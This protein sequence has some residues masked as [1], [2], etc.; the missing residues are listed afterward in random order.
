MN[1]GKIFAGWGFRTRT[2]DYEPGDEL[3]VYVTG[4]DGSPV[5]RIGDTELRLADGDASLVD[6]RI[7]V[8]VTAFDAESHT[9]SAERID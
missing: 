2:P 9:G 3:V 8:R 6:E 5:V 7:R 1:L 4:F